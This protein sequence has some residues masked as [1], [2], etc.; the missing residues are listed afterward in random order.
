ME[1]S[2]RDA[3][4]VENQQLV[5]HTLHKYYPR[6]AYD[7]DIQQ[8]GM[9]GLCKAAD[10]YDPE[11]GKFSTFA[12]KYILNTL[13]MEFR[14][15]MRLCRTADTVSI[16]LETA[17]DCTLQDTLAGEDDVDFCDREGLFKLLA[18]KEKKVAEL[19]EQGYSQ[20]EICKKLG[21]TR[22]NVSLLARKIKHKWRKYL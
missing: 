21:Y 10:N 15:R 17:E 2:E 5:F 7:E 22:S 12:T 13:R 8:V 16:E 4:I 20:V 9:I 14:N 1:M 11:K 3:L 18:P 19:L 6:W